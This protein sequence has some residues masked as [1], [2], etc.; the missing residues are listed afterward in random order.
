MAVNAGMIEK[1]NWLI[2]FVKCVFRNNWITL[3]VLNMNKSIVAIIVVLVAILG[4]ALLYSADNS[5]SDGDRITLNVSSEGPME[6]SKVIENI[7]THD[8]YKDHDNETVNWME[9]LG[10]KY[11]WF[12]SDEIVIMDKWDSDKI[13]SQYVCDASFYEEF[14]C[15]VVEKHPLGDLKYHRDVLLVKNVEYIGENVISYDV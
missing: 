10:Y 6:L 11:V 14:S 2:Q 3:G 8:Y 13:P 4:I 12:S 1:A 5:Q 7:K 15:N 9:S